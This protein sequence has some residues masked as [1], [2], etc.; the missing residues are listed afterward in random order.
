M[1]RDKGRTAGPQLT[2]FEF[3][4]PEIGKPH[5]TGPAFPTTELDR[6]GFH[7]PPA[8]HVELFNIVLWHP[9]PVTERRLQESYR[10]RGG[11]RDGASEASGAQGLRHRHTIQFVCV[12]TWDPKLTQNTGINGKLLFHIVPFLVLGG[13]SSRSRAHKKEQ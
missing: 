4:K 13:G 9:V 10:A 6:T 5:W 11:Q 3:C 12:Q 7:D 8:G 2:K 1:S